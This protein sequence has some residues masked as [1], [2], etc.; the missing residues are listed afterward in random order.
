MAETATKL[1]VKT[2][3]AAPTPTTWNPLAS[4][5]KAVDRVFEDFDRH[6]WPFSRG[7]LD[8]APLFSDDVKWGRVPAVDVVESDNSFSISAE[9]PGIDEKHV[10]VKVSGGVLT[11]AGEKQEEKEEKRKDYTLSERRYGSFER[12][13][14]L[15]E[16]VDTDKIDATFKNGVLRLKVPKKLGAA[17]SEKKIAVKVA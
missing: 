1:P 13:F 7:T 8:I 12:S 16:G 9:L 2:T 15:P 14:R 10:D 17:K 5:Q 4:L 11:I 3:S 6:A